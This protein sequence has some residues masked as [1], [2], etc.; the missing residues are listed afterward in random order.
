MSELDQEPE[1]LEEETLEDEKTRKSIGEEIWDNI[2]SL[3]KIFVTFGIITSVAYQP[4]KIPSGSMIPT[5]LVGDFLL[6]DKFTYG[7]TN[8]SF[9]MWQVT[10]PLPK[11]KHRLMKKH[12]PKQGDVV[13]F[14]NPKDE[15]KN[16][17]KRIIGMPGDKIQ[18][19]NGVVNINDKPCKITEEG[20]YSIM[21]RGN[22]DTY[23]KYTE[24][25]PNG[26]KHVFIKKFPFGQGSLDNVGPFNVPEG[27]YFVMGD[28]RDNSQD[29]R[30]MKYVGF[31]PLERIMGQAKWIFFSSSCEW[32]QVFKWF[33]SMR[34]ERF[35]TSI[36]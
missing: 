14:R 22:Y 19:I 2:K 6:C 27:H 24:E 12:D 21:D 9:R 15:D 31:I 18:I 10:L 34:F 32:Y 36:L 1:K 29:S 35:F 8:D 13:V 4:F 30:V 25:L 5:L 26:Y 20:S 7:Y 16:Y 23:T 33:F 17:I 3:A 28:N 11:F